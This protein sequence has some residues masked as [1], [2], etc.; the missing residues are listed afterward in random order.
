ML[1]P[2]SLVL[3]PRTGVHDWLSCA[4]RASTAHKF[5]V[6]LVLVRALGARSQHGRRSIFVYR[7]GSVSTG[8]QPGRTLLLFDDEL[9]APV[10]LHTILTMLKTEGSILSIARRLELE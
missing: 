3:L 7:G 1:L 2:S 5:N 8:G 9:D 10:P 4:H 6:R